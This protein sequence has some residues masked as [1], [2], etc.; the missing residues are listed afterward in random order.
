MWIWAVIAIFIIGLD[1]FTKYLVVRNISEFDTVNVIKGVIE[2]VNV[3]NTG[4]AFSVL[5]NSTWLLALISAVF[6]IGI[7]IYCIK[8]KPTD[9]LYC[10]GLCM[11][12]A[13]A[14]GN[15]ID[16]IFRG[17]VVDFIKTVFIDF[18][19]FN[20]ADISITLGAVICIIYIAFFTKGAENGRNNS[21]TLS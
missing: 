21:D 3:K 14:F 12:F 15:G 1:Q 20:I 7:I 11:M 4:A 6:C 9:K 8:T 18:P 19:V 17:S 16:R 5:N 2:F 10:T 13:G